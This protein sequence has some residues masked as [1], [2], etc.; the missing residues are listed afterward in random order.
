MGLVN[1][2]PLN[3]SSFEKNEVGD[4]GGRERRG[5]SGRVKGRGERERGSEGK[6]R[7]ERG[8]RGKRGKRPC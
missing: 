5:L 4:R 2:S 8:K 7:E 3:Y 6:E 1:G